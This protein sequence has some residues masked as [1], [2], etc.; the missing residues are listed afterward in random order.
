MTVWV[1][2]ILGEDHDLSG[3]DSGRPRL[4]HWLRTQAHRAARSGTARTHVWVEPGGSEV[5][6]YYA[7]APT[8]V[9]RQDLPRAMTGGVSVIPSYLLARLALDR[10]LQGQ[11]LGSQLLVD[12]LE[13]VVAAAELAAGRLV[14]VDAIDEAAAAFYRHHDFTPVQGMPGRLVMKISTARAALGR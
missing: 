6:A 14:V 11:R 3:F 4:D 8:E 10:R 7:L 13:V 5:V 12:A 1:S 9:R 2:E